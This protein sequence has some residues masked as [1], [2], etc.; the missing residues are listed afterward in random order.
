[1]ISGRE[2]TGQLQARPAVN[3]WTL[4][5]TWLVL[6]PLLARA[7]V[8]TSTLPYWDLDPLIFSATNTSMAP[9][10]SMLVDVCVLIGAALMLV[11]AS[12][13][14]GASPRLLAAFLAL[15]AVFAA[16]VLG[17]AFF[18]RTPGLRWTPDLG[19]QRIGLSW[20]SG[21]AAA[22]AMAISGQDPRVRRLVVGVFLGFGVLLLL[23][24]LQQ[25]YVDHPRIVADFAADK[26]RA[27]AA[28]G[29]TEGS[30]MA[31]GFERRLIQPEA[32]GYFGLANVYATLAACS[33]VGACVLAVAG[34]SQ[35]KRTGERWT[36]SLMLGI[37][38]LASIAG[39]ALSGA[40]GGVAAFL[41]GLTAAT[42]LWG[43]SGGVPILGRMR[44]WSG[45]I[46]IGI[47][48]ATLV[49]VVVR[50]LVGERS[51]ELSLLFRWFYMQGA[52]RAFLAHP[53]GVGPDGFQIVYSMLKP[54]LSPEDVVS[55]HSIVLDYLA[56][57]GVFGLSGAALLL[58]FAWR[59]TSVNAA[60][61]DA[62]ESVETFS[63]D[64]SEWRVML[65]IIAT[66][67]IAPLWL[68]SP[69]IPPETMAVRIL[70]AVGWAFVAAA[71]CRS[72]AS[73]RSR[74]LALAGMACALL[75]HMQIDVA[76][77]WPASCGLCLAVLGLAAAG[78]AG[79]GA[80]ARSRAH[81]RA[82]WA[83]ASLVCAIG[84]VAAAFA[85]LPAW[86]WQRHLAQAAGT[87]E[88][89]AEFGARLSALRPSAKDAIVHDGRPDSYRRVVDDLGRLLGRTVPETDSGLR[90]A[91]VELERQILPVAARELESAFAVAPSDRRVLREASRLYLRLAEAEG[92]MQRPEGAM[93]AATKAIDVFGFVPPQGAPQGSAQP[94]WASTDGRWASLLHER[95]AALA[96]T[97]ELRRADLET[98][99]ACVEWSM[100]RDPYNPEIPLRAF[101]LAERLGDAARARAH[102][103]TAL[104]VN[105][106]QRLDPAVRSLSETDLDALR[107]VLSA[108]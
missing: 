42:L 63:I 19:D 33:G 76:G 94:G 20:L 12:R 7:A 91:L 39:L 54:P 102:A 98:A 95:R 70:G 38:A 100:T 32:S 37:A 3:A 83:F 35:R 57:L 58:V 23:R 87:V 48:A 65:G 14:P 56:T 92:A 43:M 101:R 80:A 34:L 79:N 17:H 75:A 72:R 6:G 68:E 96:P 15:F 73:E 108:P 36:N 77:T 105:E 88:P 16:G 71:V 5:G 30:V 8:T 64:R 62:S 49:L 53:L 89:I 29:W 21:L 85:A 45:W 18:E 61:T 4:W 22:C 107:R 78:S 74:R 9:A 93:A 47:V 31:R 60:Q 99:L 106:L 44:S 86:R 13:G 41:G 90:E 51:H 11:G 28:H 40:K 52:I 24:A 25:V 103:E 84:V 27:L 81:T 26:A 97:E 2:S 10:G 59:S 46:A 55:P 104:R 50:G 82:A 67:T 66:A 69:L 1:M